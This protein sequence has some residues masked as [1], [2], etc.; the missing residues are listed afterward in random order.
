LE[1]FKH[2]LAD[3]P[4]DTGLAFVF[5]QHL[6]P[7]HHSMLAEILA[8][9]AAMPVGVAA[10]GLAVEAN[11]VYV[12]PAEADLTIADGKLKLAPRDQSPGLHLPI[13]RFFR[14]LAEEC[15]SQAIGVVLS[16]TGSDGSAG[17]EAIKAAGG[18]TF[19]QDRA[20][21]KFNA[22]PQAAAA[23]GCV[24]FVLPPERIAAGLARIGRHP[25]VADAAAPDPTPG[26]GDEERFAAILATLH[27][28]TGIDFSLYREKMVKRRILRR[29]ALGSIDGLAEYSERL[30]SDSD[31]LAALQR[32]LL[33][34]VTSFFRDRD[35]FERLKRVA[36]P[37]ILE[38][39]PAHD[40]IRV[41]V[42][43]C[44]TGE[45]AFSIAILLREYLAETGASF[46]VQIF[47]SDISLP[48]IEKARAGRYLENIAADITPERLDR[49]FKKIEGGYQVDKGLREMCIFA[50]HNLIEDPPFSKLDLISCRNVLIYLGSVQEEIVPIF[51]Y[52]LK[53]NGVLML[54]ASE[55]P[56]AGRLFTAADRE[57]RIYVRRET[58]G[59][60]R[61]P[62]SPARGAHGGAPAGGAAAA[63]ATG[64]WDD[65]DAHQ[66][67][68]RILLSRFSPAGVVV[69]ED[70][71]VVEIRGKASPYLAL[72]PGRVSFNLMK[73]IPETGLFLE[74]EKLIRQVRRS[75]EPAR[76]GRVVYD[77]NGSAGEL[78]VEVTP[79]EAGRKRLILVL[80]EPVSPAGRE[81]G[82]LAAA[83]AGDIRDRQIARLKQQLG[84]AKQ[85]FLSALEEHQVSREE[86][87]NTTEEALS[88]RG[89]AK[90]QRGAGDRQGGVAIHQRR[91]DHGQRRAADQEYGGHARARFRA[92]HRRSR[93]AAAAGARSGVADQDGQPGLLPDLPGSAVRNR[94]P[95]HLFDR[96]RRLGPPRPAGPAGIASARRLLVSGLRGRAGSSGDRA[97]NADAGRAPPRSPR[98]DSPLGGGR[99]R[100]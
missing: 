84:E 48:A 33:I 98:R 71:E 80:F 3:L 11:H 20:T 5:V 85:R 35:S 82:P 72:P 15:G 65:V 79:L 87:R 19:A 8:R 76:A 32:D 45:E 59:K 29:L 37:R 95:I 43:G 16:G 22:M 52:A 42:A 100:S 58:A 92:L 50:R 73:L 90:P 4:A 68:D 78:N 93:P 56:A 14:S 83:R 97:Q 77:N 91:A 47:A 1:A 9:S 27:E 88:Q 39:R 28:A 17:L 25:Y 54:G 57:H 99:H 94:G 13:D 6:D 46:P 89:T 49:Y 53:P 7:K 74:V 40:A 61:V 30:A 38:G 21:A 23:A 63:P 64:L 44:A 51:H 60:P 69:D 75:G 66:E 86:S 2:L 62:R 31:E 26:G 34:G 67:V 36:F 70:L 12:I 18:V 41:W 81:A 96:A 10:D 55:T 24:D